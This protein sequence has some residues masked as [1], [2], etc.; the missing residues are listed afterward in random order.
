MQLLSGLIT[1][2]CLFLPTTG[3]FNSFVTILPRSES[4]NSVRIDESSNVSCLVD[5]LASDASSIDFRIVNAALS[6]STV[7]KLLSKATMGGFKSF[8]MM[9]CNVKSGN[10]VKLL[11]ALLLPTSGTQSISF[12]H[13]NLDD[14][15]ASVSANFNNSDTIL[16]DLSFSL[17]NPRCT[18]LLST[19]LARLHSLVTLVLDGVDLSSEAGHSVVQ[20]IRYHPSIRHVSLSSCALDDDCMEPLALTLKSNDKLTYLVKHTS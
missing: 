5:D 19:G 14:P 12:H 11:S 3:R 6:Q 9:N 17:L 13:C 18:R 20:S 7:D 15:S 8:S 1:L 10:S 2:L 16:L 4:N